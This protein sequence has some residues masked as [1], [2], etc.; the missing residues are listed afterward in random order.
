MKRIAL[1][2]VVIVFGSSLAEARRLSSSIP[3]LRDQNGDVV[4]IIKDGKIVAKN[5]T[6][7]TDPV[8]ET[9]PYVINGSTSPAF[10]VGLQNGGTVYIDG[11]LFVQEDI[12][13]NSNR[14]KAIYVPKGGIHL[15]DD[16]PEDNTPP[17][18][19]F[20]KKVKTS[21]LTFKGSAMLWEAADGTVTSTMTATELEIGTIT[22]TELSADS[23]KNKN[24][25]ASTPA[26]EDCNEASEEGAMYTS[27]SPGRA[28]WCVDDGA[29]GYEWRYTTLSP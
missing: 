25:G 22:A 23:V 12:T 16:E 9:F 24:S 20:S 21:T 4:A 8:N 7:S 13:S 10:T 11:Y 15:S 14:P 28:Y 29:S 18:Q 27:R 19:M 26:A 17:G 2:L 1:L 3:E 6:V 5:V